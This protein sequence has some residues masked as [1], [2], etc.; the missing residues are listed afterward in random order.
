MNGKELKSAIRNSGI[1][2]SEI[3]EKTGI[4]RTT[5]YTLYKE[6]EIEQHY[7]DK[8]ASAGVVF[9]V[10]E[11]NRTGKDS[12][13]YLKAENFWLKQQIAKQESDLLLL[14]AKNKKII[15]A[16]EAHNKSLER[17]NVTLNA[18]VLG[19]VGEKS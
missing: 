12:I 15:D 11:Q 3:I 13:D 9:R 4:K 18:I 6:N 17:N 10:P 1:S 2:A 14:E 7:I 19:K 8:I 5:F 16:I